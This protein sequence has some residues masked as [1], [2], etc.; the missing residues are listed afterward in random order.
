MLQLQYKIAALTAYL[1]AL[2]W[3]T[4]CT[5]EKGNGNTTVKRTDTEPFKRIEIYQRGS[6]NPLNWFGTSNNVRI[7]LIPDGSW[8]ISVETDENLHDCIQS[9]IDD[10]TLIITVHNSLNSGR[11]TE[12]FI[13]CSDLDFIGLYGSPGI[14]NTDTIRAGALRIESSGASDLNLLVKTQ[15][16]KV[17]ISGSSEVQIK[18]ITQTFLSE[19]AGSADIRADELQSDTCKLELS[20]SANC[21]VN[22]SVYLDVDISGSAEVEYSGTPQIKQEIS[23]SGN[24]RKK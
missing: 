5:G 22:A 16:L 9:R 11:G 14:Y 24:I 6:W 2:L 7:K 18:G 12:I 19:V 8:A 13:H 10:E 3:F 17:E 20:G 1:M 4:G 23:G 15:Q 21:Q